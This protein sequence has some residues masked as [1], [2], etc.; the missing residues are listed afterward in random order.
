MEPLAPGIT[1]RLPGDQ[2]Q[3]YSGAWTQI[4]A[5]FR[6]APPVPPRPFS[7]DGRLS[8]PTT[9][10]LNPCGSAGGAEIL[11]RPFRGGVAVPCKGRRR[12]PIWVAHQVARPK[13]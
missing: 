7:W 13:S 8:R 4:S 1:V 6:N 5:P 9:Q 2:L 10:L 11:P 3:G 12:T